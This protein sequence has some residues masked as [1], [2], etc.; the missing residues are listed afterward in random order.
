[1]TKSVMRGKI[2][3][4]SKGEI[5]EMFVNEKEDGY[6]IVQIE[7]GFND[8]Y[9]VE[10]VEE[11]PGVIMVPVSNDIDDNIFTII[12]KIFKNKCGDKE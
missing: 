7:H 1:M 3:I 11:S 8:D 9:I 12:S 5:N 4:L 10:V 6:K 2:L